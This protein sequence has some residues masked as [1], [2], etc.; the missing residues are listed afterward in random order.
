MG[1]MNNYWLYPHMRRNTAPPA[2]SIRARLGAWWMVQV[3]TGFDACCWGFT[4]LV[5]LIPRFA[6]VPRLAVVAW[7]GRCVT[8]NRLARSSATATTTAVAPVTT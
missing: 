6:D 2:V 4:R 1:Y 3:Q 7:P 8:S 5:F